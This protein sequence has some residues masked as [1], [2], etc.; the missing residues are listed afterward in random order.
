MGVGGEAAGEGEKGAV[1][2]TVTGD[3]ALLTDTLLFCSTERLRSRGVRPRLFLISALF[4]QNSSMMSFLA[5]VPS[6]E[7]S[8][9]PAGGVRG[10]SEATCGA[11]LEAGVE[12]A[13]GKGWVRTG[14]EEERGE[15]GS[16]QGR[17]WA[18]MGERGLDDG[19]Q[20]KDWDWVVG[21]LV[22]A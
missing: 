10:A 4:C 5:G 12:V 3:V 11:G 1:S 13:P 21:G 6:M 7:S 16:R 18:Q 2:E 20:T 15:E 22:R 14:E 9:M 19:V 17:A 8:A